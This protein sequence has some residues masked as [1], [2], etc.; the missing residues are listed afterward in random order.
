MTAITL[1]PIWWSLTRTTGITAYF[2]TGLCCVLVWL[3]NRSSRQRHA[4]SGLAIRLALI[5]F[6]FCADMIL[7]WRLAL[8]TF[9]VNLFM[10]YNLYNQRHSMQ[11]GLLFALGC[12]LLFMLLS[13]YRRFQRRTGA[14]LAVSGV[15]LSATLWLM[16]IISIHEVDASLYHLVDGV[17]VIALLWVLACSLTLAGIGLEARLAARQD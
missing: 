1:F 12:L 9:F 11:L 15:L 3:R 10:E 6:L 13:V 5:E 7:E 2:V 16:E 8:H 14:F 17:M 4:I